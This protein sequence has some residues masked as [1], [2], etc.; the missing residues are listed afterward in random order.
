MGAYP[1]FACIRV[2]L[3]PTSG[4]GIGTHDC[5]SGAWS[6][7]S[8]QWTGDSPS[9]KLGIQTEGRAITPG[10]VPLVRPRDCAREGRWGLGRPS[11]HPQYPGLQTSSCS[12]A[13]S[14]CFFWC[15]SAD[16]TV[17]SRPLP[18][19]PNPMSSLWSPLTELSS[20]FLPLPET[21]PSLALRLRFPGFPSGPLAAQS[22]FLVVS[23][24]CACQGAPSPHSS[25][26]ISSSL[27]AFKCLPF[28][29]IESYLLLIISVLPPEGKLHQA[30]T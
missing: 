9:P 14:S 1:R 22:V 7:K 16:L 6:R 11:G 30:G 12:R 10:F 18:L 5:S 3:S 25:L 26:V 23:L 2:L 24:T 13:H 28:T 29:T 8:Q 21:H 4:I 15:L 20:I 27:V 17:T 19:L